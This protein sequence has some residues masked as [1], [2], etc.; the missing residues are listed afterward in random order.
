MKKGRNTLDGCP[1][2]LVSGPAG[3]DPARSLG[4]V[5]HIELDRMRSHP[6]ASDFFHLQRT[7]RIEH[8]VR[9]DAALG[10]EL[11]ILVEMLDRHVERRAY[12]LYLLGLC[13]RQIVEIL[14]DRIARMN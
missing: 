2:L 5:V 11:A 10:Q 12:I 9:K 3:P 7:V 4:A 1:V 13:R 14:V 6:E 8:V